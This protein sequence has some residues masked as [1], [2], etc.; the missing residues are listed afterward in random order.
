M[1]PDDIRFK[2]VEKSTADYLKTF[3]EPGAF[4][5]AADV[6]DAEMRYLSAAVSKDIKHGKEGMMMT[7]LDGQLKGSLMAGF[8]LLGSGAQVKVGGGIR[9]V[10]QVADELSRATGIEITSDILRTQLMKKIWK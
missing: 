1:K 8:K 2:S 4:N 6:T 3:R 5:E 10:D 9:A 7:Q